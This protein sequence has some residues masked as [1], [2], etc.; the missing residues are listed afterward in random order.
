[1]ALLTIEM[2]PDD[3][4]SLRSWACRLLSEL[5]S[6]LYALDSSNVLEARSVNAAGIRGI[7]SQEQLG[8]IDISKISGDRAYVNVMPGTQNGVAFFE[9]EGTQDVAA[10]IYYKHEGSEPGL[11]IDGGIKSIY[12]DTESSIH[13]NGNVITKGG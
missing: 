12:I 11:H 8:D 10:R 13:I 1:M 4:Q 2:P 7:I 6:L 9:K 3:A 5:R